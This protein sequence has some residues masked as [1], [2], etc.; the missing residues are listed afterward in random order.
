MTSPQSKNYFS[1][2]SAQYARY[3]PSY[4][5][6]LIEALANISPAQNIALDCGCGT[7]Q[8][9]ILLAK[10]F[11]QV[12][13]T[14]ASLTQI[15]NA[16]PCKGVTYRVAVAENSDLPDASVDI[17]TVAQAAHWLDLEKF[18][19]EVQ[20]VSKPNAVIALITYGVLHIEGHLNML[21]QHFYHQTIAA[22]W[23]SE[24]RHVD[25]GYCNLN[26]PFKEIKLPQ[27]SIE[28]WWSI[29][30]LIGYINT[31]SAI[32]VARDN[33]QQ[34]IIQ[35][36]YEELTQQWGDPNLPKKISWP[37]SLRVGHV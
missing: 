2:A 15:Q 28:A 21:M 7:G 35:S 29:D 20:R 22:Y 32:Q 9:S 18:Y 14:D 13:A 3:R 5:M 12:I 16:Q 26:F 19:K 30:E 36:F 6:V 10:R 1:S 23:P 4:P 25:N 34:D 31:W 37:L 27:F 24:R 11:N 17:I 33:Q 8:L